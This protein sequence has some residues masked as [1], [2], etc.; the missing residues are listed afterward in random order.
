[1]AFDLKNILLKFSGPADD[2]FGDYIKH[3]ANGGLARY[4]AIVQT[5]GKAGQPLYAH[6]IDMV[7]TLVRLLDLLELSV[8]EQRV[9]MLALSIHDLNKVPEFL[10]IRS[11]NE[12][13]VPEN[14]AAEL[15]RVGADEFFPAWREYLLDIEALMRAHSGHYQVAG[16]MLNRRQSRFA[17]GNERVGQLAHLMRGLDKLDLSHDLRE[18]THK[19]DFLK[20]F[21]A[22]CSTQYGL[23]Y[24][25]VAEQRGILSNV[26]HNR[27][28]EYMQTEH[29]LLPLL[30]YPDGVVYLIERG[31]EIR[32]SSEDYDQMGDSV[33][34]FLE[35]QTRGNFADFIKAGNQGIKIQPR[36]LALGVPFPRM[37]QEVLNIIERKK[38][39]TLDNMETKARERTTQRVGEDEGS[40]ADGVRERL[41]HVYLLPRDEETLHL[42]ELV[43]SYYIFLN[44]HFKKEVD[45]PWA[46]VYDLL[47]V[48]EDSREMFD[49]FDPNYDRAYALVPELTL[50]Y[51][52]T[53]KRIIEDGRTLLATSTAESSWPQTFRQYVRQ[54]V[55]F[56]FQLPDA[57]DFSGYL[58]QYV[59]G[60]H[61]QSAYGSTS[62]E[63]ELWRAGDVPKTI[64]VQQFSNRLAGGPG[65][66]VKR[67]DPVTK[68]QFLLEKLNYPP[69]NRASTFY[70]HIYPYAFYSHAYLAMWRRTVRELA[71]LD[72]SALFIKTDDMLRDLFAGEAIQLHV[73]A[74]NSNGLPLP[75]A[76]EML[77]NL[78]I[79]PL[80]APGANNTEQFWYAFT[81]AFAMHKFVGGRVVLTRSAVPVT[82][83]GEFG[84][85]LLD[86]IPLSLEGLLRQNNFDYKEVG[87]LQQ[88]LRALYDIYARVFNPRSGVNEVLALAESL[89]DG[90]LGVYHTTERLLLQRMR[91]DKRASSSEWAIIRAA[92][93]VTPSLKQ[94]SKTMGGTEVIETI[95]KLARLAT[96][97][98]LKG[99]SRNKNSLM[100]PLDECF[101]KMQRIEPP[102]DVGTMRA[103]TASDIFE[104][105]IRIRDKKYIGRA[106]QV[107]IDAFVNA[108]F[109]NLLADTYQGNR[110]RLLNDEK[111]IRSAFLFH[112]RE[113]REA[114]RVEKAAEAEATDKSTETSSQP[115]TA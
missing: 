39:A 57:V 89:N 92:A 19:E 110:Q 3:A 51:E 44:K 28:A 35:D 79:W 109:D 37:W 15:E 34:T 26:I 33:A 74:S 10:H 86:E 93:Q 5:G 47:D 62:F 36:C 96:E 43:R 88:R 12:I 77:G 32:L 67:V 13:A 75:G 18:T 1:M 68:A 91:D 102:I 20:D 114:R 99:K 73:S 59:A 65:D 22:F 4:R 100:T 16:N 87:N 108:F 8:E 63:T 71:E 38:Y 78:L 40:A 107:K 83:A 85:L 115:V 105:L 14:I 103:A 111:L 58:K 101:S 21:N 6:V 25:V 70:L 69:A 53:A 29:D 61:K 95:E 106:T 64:K 54:N 42:G 98:N 82:G 27:V 7:F 81:C 45:D 24:H 66:P 23:V 56:S 112:V 52:E 46:R 55:Q 90:A 17:L 113:L 84:S 31:R 76:P 50:N 11:Y 30:Y 72:I 49:Y 9:L 60:N 41:A 104:Y 80:N 2:V 97:G 48:P 94:L